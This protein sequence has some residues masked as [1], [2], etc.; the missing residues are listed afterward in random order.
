M[1][2]SERLKHLQNL[3]LSARWKGRFKTISEAL[4]FYLSIY[5]RDGDP[6]FTTE[7]NHPVCKSLQANPDFRVKCHSYCRNAMMEVLNNESCKVY[8]CYA[9]LMSF[10]L[11][12]EYLEE[13]AVIVGQ[14]SFSDYDDFRA[15]TKQIDFV[16]PETL[17]I[18]GPIKFTTSENARNACRLVDSSINHLLKSAEETIIL[19]KRIDTVKDMLGMWSTGTQ[20]EQDASLKKLIA[21]LYTLLNIKPIAFFMSEGPRGGYKS[22]YSLQ[23]EGNKIPETFRISEQD[24]IVHEFLKGRPSISSAD[25]IMTVRNGFLKGVRT[26]TF[27]P[28]LVNQKLEGILGV[29][30]TY[31]SE[32]D[33]DIIS[34]FCKQVAMQMENQKLRSELNRKL[35]RFAAISN[36]SESITA[37]KNYETLFQTI[38]DKSAEL[39]AAEQGSLMLIDSKADTL[40]LKANKSSDCNVPGQLIFHKGEGIAGKVAVHGESLLVKDVENDPRFMQKNRL[41]YKTRSFVSVPLKIGER[42]IGVLNLSDKTTGEVFN[43]EDLG[44]IQSFATHAAIV[45]ERNVFCKQTEELR[46]L[47]ITDPLTG[48]LNRRYL[49]ERL[50]EEISRSFR[51]KRPLSIL[52]VDIDGFK[53]YNDKLGH[54]MGDHA[55]KLIGETTLNALRTVDIIARYGGDEFVV[56]LPETEKSVAKSI[57]ERLIS[58]VG[59]TEFPPAKERLTLSIGLASYPEHDSTLEQL[60]QKADNALYKAKSKGGNTVEVFL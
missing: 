48:L 54:S 13:K 18:T 7:D 51:Y 23:R 42:I 60:L 24:I 2:E 35:D 32:S 38:L 36:M 20:Q 44:L 31:L 22:K 6:I 34:G 16:N 56:I 46:T 3:F 19:K 45:M 17:T 57:A 47:A 25:P 39:L 8:K 41:R 29:F 12:V 30:D 27:F 52:M 21:S 33:T 28:L 26:F 55:L 37:I 5:S 53:G 40:L 58:D 14:G 15:F 10:A 9:G 11:P 59:K 4:G 43:E 50:E 1:F 49:Y